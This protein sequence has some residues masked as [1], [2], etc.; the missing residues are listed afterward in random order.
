LLETRNK[1]YAT[2]LGANEKKTNQDK[3]QTLTRL[4]DTLL[5]K[6]MNGALKVKDL[7]LEE[8]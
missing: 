3:I 2:T 5:P 6:L 4:R 8:V 7:K 1:P